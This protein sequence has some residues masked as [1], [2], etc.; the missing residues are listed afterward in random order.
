MDPKRGSDGK[1]AIT[2]PMGDKKLAGIAAEDIGKCAYGVFKRGSEFIRKKIGISGGHPTGK[3]MAD[4]MTKAFGQ[5]VVYNSIPFDVYRSL[6]FPGAEDLG[7]MFQFYHDF[8]EYFCNA[9]SI[10]FTKSL[11][12]ELLSFDMW[13]EKYKNKITLE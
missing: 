2:L 9:R 5:E 11:N 7:N 1:L 12:P 13:L 10:E 8:E 4:S 6:G 3:M